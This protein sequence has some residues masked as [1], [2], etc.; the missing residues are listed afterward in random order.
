M[1]YDLMVYKEL[2][3][4]YNNFSLDKKIKEDYSKSLSFFIID[5]NNKKNY[6]KYYLKKL[7]IKEAFQ[8]INIVKFYLISLFFIF[9]YLMFILFNTQLIK[10][11]EFLFSILFLILN[12][13][14]Y[15]LLYITI[16]YGFY[17][18]YYMKLSEEN[19]FE[20]NKVLKKHIIKLLLTNFKKNDMN[21]LIFVIYHELHHFYESLNDI[22]HNEKN[23]DDYS[24]YMLKKYHNIDYKLKR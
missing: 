10:D 11:Y 3:N 1:I 4:C 18:G 16:K 7:N 9:L 20:E 13:P 15:M 17:Y 23:S 21:D 8:L 2:N 5:D 24:L 14:L 19:F 22:K 12:I 6:F